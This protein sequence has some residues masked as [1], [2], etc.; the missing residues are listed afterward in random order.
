M[1]FSSPI[2]RP[3]DA[4]LLA[5]FAAVG[6]GEACIE[7]GTGS[8][9]VACILAT[10]Y[11]CKR[12]LGIDIQEEFVA[13]AKRSIVM[14]GLAGCVEARH[15]DVRRPE[16]LCAAQSFDAV[17]FNPPYRRLRSGRINPDAGKAMA[18]HEITGSAGD[19]CAAAAHALRHG[20]RACAIYPATRAVE[21]IS[22]MRTCRLEPKRMRLV[23]SSPGGVGQFVLL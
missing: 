5:H 10:R 4:L 3:F 22:R 7:L 11:G 12:V 17:V 16:S 13:M 20:G 2:L 19:F 9:V 1:R 18:R 6:E 23:H 15:G 8:G 21:L 14:N